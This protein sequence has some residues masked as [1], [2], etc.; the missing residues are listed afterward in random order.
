MLLLDRAT[1]LLGNRCQADLKSSAREELK[2]LISAYPNPAS[3]VKS[4]P[5][6]VTIVPLLVMFPAP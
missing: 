1:A 5:E 4:V 3:L 2:A 6:P